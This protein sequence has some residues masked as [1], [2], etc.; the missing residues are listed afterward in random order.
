VRG[1]RS[2]AVTKDQIATWRVAVLARDG[3][4]CRRCGKGPEE[5]AVVEAARIHLGDYTLANG[6]TLCDPCLWLVDPAEGLALI[7]SESSS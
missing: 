5:G 7:G 1:V 6:L 3:A 2:G 4:K